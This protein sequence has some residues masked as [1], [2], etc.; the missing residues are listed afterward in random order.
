VKQRQENKNKHQWIS[1]TQILEL[2]LLI[3]D[4]MNALGHG[5]PGTPQMGTLTRNGSHRSLQRSRQPT[6][7]GGTGYSTLSSTVAVHCSTLG[8]TGQQQ[9]QGPQP[10]LLK[11]TPDH[12]VGASSSGTVEV[13][14][15]R[16][17]SKKRTHLDN[18][19]A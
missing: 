12:Q 9:Q 19:M 16:T 3:A 6:T 2:T 5:L 13:R 11:S 17:D 8:S 10:D 18:G 14:L 7:G 15:H 4:Y 1:D